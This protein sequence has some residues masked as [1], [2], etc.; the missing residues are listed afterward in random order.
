MGNLTEIQIYRDI[1][2]N[3]DISISLES[4]LDELESCLIE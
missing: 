3:R 2:L 1:Y 4:S